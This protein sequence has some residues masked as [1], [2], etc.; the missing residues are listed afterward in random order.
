MS[1]LERLAEW[2]RK[3][4]VAVGTGHGEGPPTPE[5]PPPAVPAASAPPPG[6]PPAPTP[7]PEPPPVV[8]TPPVPVPP[9]AQAPVAEAPVPPPP[10][11]IPKP[12]A[13]PATAAPPPP[14]PPPAP[15][16]APAAATAPPAPPPTPAAPPPPPIP[17]ERRPPAQPATSLKLDA[18]HLLPIG[19]QEL[20]ESIESLIRRGA[21]RIGGRGSI[22]PGSDERTRLIDRALITQGLL[23]PEQI[24]EIHQAGDEMAQ[25]RELQWGATREAARRGHQA[26]E[27]D[28]EA[29]A[30]LKEQKKK[31]AAERRQKHAADVARRKATD[32][33][34]LGRGVSGRLNQRQ[35]D[36]AKLTASG[37]PI[38]VTPADVAVVLDIGIPGLRWLAFHTTVASRVHYVSFTVPKK[39]GGTRTLHA[40]HR[41]LAAAQQWILDNI[42]GKLAVE[43]PAHGFVARRS[44]LTNAKPHVGKAVVV[45]MD[46]EGFFPNIVFPRVRSVF[47]RLGYSPCVATIL[48]LLCTE[49]PR[50]PVAYEGKVYHVATGP[51]GL[52]QGAC[53]SPGL[54][55]QVARRLDKRLEGLARKLGIT[56]TRYADDITFSGDAG[57]NEKIGW[58]MAK[59][60]HIAEEERFAVNEKKSRVLRRNTAQRVT[61]LVVNDKPGV[62]R[63]V[64]RRL[65]AILHRAKTEG[66][67][68][69]NREGRPNFVAWLRGMIAYIHMVRP[70]VGDRLKAQ[71]EAV[72]PRQ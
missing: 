39:S 51:R 46:L 10:L 66:L 23:S 50:R 2:W 33:I 25:V 30:R 44:I 6:P 4:L 18:A 40:P 21:F 42:V 36:I 26:V 48:A 27:A 47:Q 55:N 54:S 62:S 13:E 58:L 29:R 31:E 69:Q 60:R 63:K 15:A 68:A 7:P 37:L 61:G 43:P 65:R 9:P 19:R 11:T 41:R 22:P 32:I 72:L 17:T 35:S 16:P 56:Y 14:A 34:F 20:K 1:F 64:V 59:V 28:R 53:T 71:L 12:T 8:A 38:L 52:P 49:C 70:E 67:E 45:N 24:I 5:P 3:L 57:L